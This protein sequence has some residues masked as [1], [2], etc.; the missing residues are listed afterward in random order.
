MDAYRIS[1]RL[2]GADSV[3]RGAWISPIWKSAMF[4]PAAGP[5]GLIYSRGE[6]GIARLAVGT[7]ALIAPSS[8]LPGGRLPWLRIYA[9]LFFAGLL[10]FCLRKLAALPAGQLNDLLAVASSATCGWSWLLTRALFREP[11]QR[12]SPWPLGA[13]ILL[14][15]TGAFLQFAG[16]S[17]GSL[18]HMAGN[19]QQLLSSTVL[20]LAVTESL[21]T[22][23]RDMP[24]PELRFRLVF[25]GGYAAL[26]VVS[27]V[28]IN[29]SPEGSFGARSG[30]GVKVTC[31][32]AA[33]LLAGLALR[34]RRLNPLPGAAPTRRR[35]PISVDDEQLACRIRELLGRESLH[36]QHDLKVAD[37]AREL[38]VPEYKVTQ[39]ITGP[40][41]FPNFNQMINHWRV[42][43]AM[44]MLGDARHANLPVLTIALD[45]GF[46]SIGPFNRAFKAQT[47]VTPTQFRA[48]SLT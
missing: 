17:E 21:R 11:G 2:S 1:L 36:L 4:F 10:L 28:W 7:D 9:G 31:A 13:V 48:A 15:A 46:G 43:R 14:T 33:M 40:L 16:S 19:L 30:D 6:T 39:C 25:A 27:A 24:A 37:L 3:K 20:L 29:Q 34:H 18:T 44:R 26:V 12:E 42:E 23:R 8:G 35:S 47:G 45:C 5:A 41:S 32:M 38:G 22:W